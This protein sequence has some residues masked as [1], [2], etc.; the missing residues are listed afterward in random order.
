MLTRMWRAKNRAVEIVLQ[1]SRRE[2]AVSQREL[3]ERLP[4][5]LGWDQTTLAKVETGRRRLDLVEFLELA[6][7]LKLDPLTL[8][9]RVAHWR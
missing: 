3:V 5:W 8:L 1:A 6:K 7:A 4:E 9:E 2:A